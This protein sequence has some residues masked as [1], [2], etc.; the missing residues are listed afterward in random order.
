M[1]GLA[2]VTDHVLKA[3][4]KLISQY[5]GS[6]S[7]NALLAAWIGEVQE[8]ED[9][10]WTLFEGLYLSNA[11]TDLLDILGRVV[12]AD[13]GSLATDD[14]YRAVIRGQIK[15]NR[16]NGSIPT[17]IAIMR[18]MLDA[19]SGNSVTA[20]ELPHASII[21]RINGNSGSAP[22]EAFLRVLR[23]AKTPGVRLYLEW[24]G[25]DG[26]RFDELPGF[27]DGT[28]ASIAEVI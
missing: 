9:A 3:Q 1:S 27:N 6:R 12:G 28:F 20:T 21:L 15:A 7:I 4:A 22:I 14:E 8:V 23:V 24:S 13:R 25:A 2:H 18:V 17:L 11:T 26:A 10:L 19:W 16:S 5:K